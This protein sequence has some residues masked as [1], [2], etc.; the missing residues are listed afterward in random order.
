MRLP[1]TIC[2]IR[3]IDLKQLSRSQLCAYIV[4]SCRN[5]AGGAHHRAVDHVFCLRNQAAVFEAKNQMLALFL[6]NSP[7]FVAGEIALGFSQVLFV[8]ALVAAT[9]NRASD[10]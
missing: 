3:E 2:L 10:G 5:F 4:R 6:I 1:S 7:L 9:G 8:G